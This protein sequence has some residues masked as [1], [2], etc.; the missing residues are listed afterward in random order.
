[1]Y[2]EVWIEESNAAGFDFLSKRK[3]KSRRRRTME[4][5]IWALLDK[6]VT[7][8]M[9]VWAVVLSIATAAVLIRIW[10]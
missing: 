8:T 7:V 4:F 5:D 2:K 3:V 1:M 10:L 9:Y 6:T